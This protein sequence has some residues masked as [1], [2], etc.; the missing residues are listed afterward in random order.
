M[1]SLSGPVAWM[2]NWL[3]SVVSEVPRR[4]VGG[5][6]LVSAVPWRILSSASDGVGGGERNTCG[7]RSLVHGLDGC[8]SWIDAASSG[9]DLGWAF[10]VI[11]PPCVSTGL[12][13]MGCSLPRVPGSPDSVAGG[14]SGDL[15]RD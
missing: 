5:D 12:V 4:T 13:A 1:T 6:T 8:W 9:V 14:A 10:G 3:P 11:I 7:T 2:S 15:R